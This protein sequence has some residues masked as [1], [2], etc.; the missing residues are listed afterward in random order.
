MLS[1]WRRRWSWRSCSW[2]A[3]KGLMPGAKDIDD[4]AHP[5]APQTG[6]SPLNRGFNDLISTSAAQQALAAQSENLT[7]W[8][9]CVVRMHSSHTDRSQQASALSIS[10]PPTRKKKTNIEQ[11]LEQTIKWLPEKS[12]AGV[13]VIDRTELELDIVTAIS[14]TMIKSSYQKNGRCCWSIMV[15]T[16][17]WDYS[18]LF[19]KEAQ[20]LV[21]RTRWQSFYQPQKY[22]FRINR[23]RQ[24][25]YQ[26]KRLPTATQRTRTN[27]ACHGVLNEPAGVG[28]RSK[29]Q[30]ICKQVLQHH[31]HLQ[32][33]YEYLP[34]WINISSDYLVI[35][36][37]ALPPF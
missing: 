23:L 32:Q 24:T 5:P 35:I 31:Q 12:N 36:M 14:N 7:M 8:S 11:S 20:G 2:A 21:S 34:Q 9:R 1:C 33:I 13:E 37:T 3:V 10:H 16:Y 17:S 18:T 6:S 29:V 4:E 30:S 22:S 15:R 28:R 27:K 25:K 19:G 26:K